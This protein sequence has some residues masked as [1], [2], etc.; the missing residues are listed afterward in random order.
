MSSRREKLLQR[1]DPK[2]LE[3]TPKLSSGNNSVIELDSEKDTLKAGAKDLMLRFFKKQELV[4]KNIAIEDGV[5]SNYQETYRLCRSISQRLS[6]PFSQEGAFRVEKPGKKLQELKKKLEEQMAEKR[7]ED[8]KK[9][10]EDYKKWKMEQ[11]Q[12]EDNESEEEEDEDEKEKITDEEDNFTHERKAECREESGS[13]DTAAQNE[14]ENKIYN[15]DVTG[16]TKVSSIPLQLIM[17]KI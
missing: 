2:L 10:V 11:N 4:F 17:S 15:D 13:R 7:N 6:L 3:I 16:N 9:R 1:I 14:S 5:D 12:K 8:Y